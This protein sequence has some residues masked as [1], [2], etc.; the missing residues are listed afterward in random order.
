M[1]PGARSSR[2]EGF[3]WLLVSAPAGQA[4]PAQALGHIQDIHHD[5]ASSTTTGI[6]GAQAAPRSPARRRKSVTLPKE[7]QFRGKRRRF[8]QTSGPLSRPA[9][10]PLRRKQSGPAATPPWAGTGGGANGKPRSVM[11][12]Q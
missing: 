12:G 11:R 3:S 7:P 4:R 9:A 8:R 10:P 5:K 6:C 2:P 1:A